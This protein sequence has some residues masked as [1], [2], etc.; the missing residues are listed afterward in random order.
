MGILVFL[1]DFEA[2]TGQPVDVRAELVSRGLGDLLDSN[3]DLLPSPV[4]KGPN[5]GPGMLVTFDVATPRE[6]DATAQ[7]WIEAPPDGELPAGRYW[8]GYANNAKPR[9]EDLQRRELVDGEP[10]ELCDGMV[11]VVPCCEYAPKRITR[12]RAT[13]REIKVPT[14]N[15]KHWVDWS[16]ALY[17]VFVSNDFSAIVESTGKVH[18]PNG[19]GFAALTLSQNYR[20]NTDVVDLLQLIDEHKAFDI[21]RIA[22]GMAIMERLMLQKKNLAT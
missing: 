12:D 21:A 3:V 7:T 2:A 13:G 20:V 17:R 19:L 9:P 5:G 22:T 10:C 18:I 6:Y 1:P 15:C 4:R 14:D 8:L 11:W 16:N